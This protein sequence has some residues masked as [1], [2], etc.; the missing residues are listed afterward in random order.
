MPVV[1]ELEMVR[2]IQQ[3]ELETNFGFV[4]NPIISSATECS[5]N[6]RPN[7]TEKRERNLWKREICFLFSLLGNGRDCRWL[8]EDFRLSLSKEASIDLSPA[9]ARRM[10][11]YLFAAIF[12]QLLGRE[13]VVGRLRRANRAGLDA[14][15]NVVNV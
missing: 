12:S 14:Q 15:I 3:L 9:A 10:R 6:K 2:P 7:A 11:V 1:D 13:I 4:M 5:R 8:D